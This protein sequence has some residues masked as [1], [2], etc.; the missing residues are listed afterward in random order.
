MVHAKLAMFRSA[1][2][3]LWSDFLPMVSWIAP[4]MDISQMVS[5]L[6]LRANTCDH[7]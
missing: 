5:L 3:S 1:I 2:Q 7:L 6:V 4:L